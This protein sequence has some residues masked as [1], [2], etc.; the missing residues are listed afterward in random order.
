[1]LVRAD[2]EP[3]WLTQGASWPSLHRLGVM[4]LR[5][6]VV[7]IDFRSVAS[8]VVPAGTPAGRAPVVV[9]SGTTSALQRAAS[10]MIEWK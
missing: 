7:A 2:G 6:G 8:P 4:K 9:P 5:F 10:S 3:A 1:M